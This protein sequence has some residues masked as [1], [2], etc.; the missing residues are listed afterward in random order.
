LLALLLLP[1][2]YLGIALWYWLGP[3][4]P[5]ATAAVPQAPVFQAP[6]AREL[7]QDATPVKSLIEEPP[8]TIPRGRPEDHTEF[9]PENYNAWTDEP[10]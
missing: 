7:S 8:V 3:R 1:A 9:G 5:Q 6:A 2:I 10:R 4:T